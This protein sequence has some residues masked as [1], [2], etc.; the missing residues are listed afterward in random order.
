MSEGDYILHQ[1]SGSPTIRG[2][3]S[4]AQVIF[5]VTDGA[6]TPPRV[7]T[8][9]AGGGRRG[10]AHSCQLVLSELRACAKP[11]TGRDCTPVHLLKW[12]RP[13]G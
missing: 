7:T 11:L 1:G 3:V 13:G 12:N 4:P 8:K 9:P 10:L 6:L 2:T 5:E